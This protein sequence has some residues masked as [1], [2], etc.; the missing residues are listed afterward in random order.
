M[1]GE[2]KVKKKKTQVYCFRFL[3][4]M[5][6]PQMLAYCIIEKTGRLDQFMIKYHDEGVVILMFADSCEWA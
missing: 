1:H 5:L 2:Y 4:S 3:N 6:P